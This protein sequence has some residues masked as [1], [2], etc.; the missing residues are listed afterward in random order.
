MA[1][2]GVGTSVNR[3]LTLQV[4]F[5]PSIEMPSPR[6]PQALSYEANLVCEIKAFPAPTIVWLKNET[7]IHN[8]GNYKIG[9]FASQEEVV[10]STLKVP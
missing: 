5:P 8:G 1:D 7:T 9:H 10:S 3:V 6:V 2:N 4:G